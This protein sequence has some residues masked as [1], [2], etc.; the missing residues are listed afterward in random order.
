METVSVVQAKFRRTLK[1]V[2][3][4]AEPSGQAWANLREQIL[5]QKEA[6]TA[7]VLPAGETWWERMGRVSL[8]PRR[9]TLRTAAAGLLAVIL[10]ITAS[11]GIP[12]LTGH[13]EQVSAAEIALADPEVQAALGH[14]TPAGIGVADNVNSNGLSRVVL[15]LPPDTAVIAD[16]NMKNHVVTHVTTQTAADVTEQLMIDIAKADPRVQALLNMGNNI[17][18][19]GAQE[20][21]ISM[22]Q[23]EK[24]L[25]S[26]RDIGISME[27]FFRRIGIDNIQDLIGFSGALALKFNDDPYVIK[28]GKVISGDAGYLVWVNLSTGKVVGIGDNPLKNMTY[29]IETVYR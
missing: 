13:T 11:I 9:L 1:M 16:V 23:D 28:N 5:S 2:T 4:D 15:T 18:Y 20:F 6:A 24:A 29:T 3:D 19:G 7:R 25:E 22:F 27:E 26:L 14:A 17:Y 12:M 10:I 21:N 8:I